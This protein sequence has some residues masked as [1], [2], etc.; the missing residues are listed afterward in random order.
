MPIA[1]FWLFS[2]TC[3]VSMPAMKPGS[4]AVG[5]GRGG[6]CRA[7]KTGP[8]ELP[9]KTLKS[10]RKVG[11]ALDGPSGNEATRPERRIGKPAALADRPSRKAQ[12][13][14]LVA[15]AERVLGEGVVA[16]QP[17][18]RD[19]RLGERRR[20]LDR[21]SPRRRGRDGGSTAPCRRRGSSAAPGRSAR[22][23]RRSGCESRWWRSA[24]GILR[25]TWLAV[26]S[27][28]RGRPSGVGSEIRK[29]VPTVRVPSPSG[30]STWTVAW[31][32]S[33]DMST[34]ID[35]PADAD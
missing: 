2:S 19:R 6:R 21:R 1:R 14:H 8:P 10:S 12:R 32:R 13:H 16:G 20:R 31:I 26:T 33:T 28:V 27:T 34:A 18:S 29:P 4:A 25:N 35:A 5:A 9:G 23:R 22:S 17:V 24:P 11:K 3:W 7:T 15:G 30:C